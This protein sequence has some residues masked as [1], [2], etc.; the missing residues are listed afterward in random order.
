MVSVGG[1]L[2]PLLVVLLVLL[3]AVVA[4]MD[5]ITPCTVCPVYIKKKIRL[6]NPIIHGNK[7]KNTICS[8]LS[9]CMNRDQQEIPEMQANLNP[10]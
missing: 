1:S 7:T 6:S 9:R 3:V 5:C 8:Y 10:G 4:V 2:F